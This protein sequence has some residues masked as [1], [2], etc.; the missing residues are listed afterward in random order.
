[1]KINYQMMLSCNINYPVHISHCELA[2]TFNVIYLN[3]FNTHTL[4][5]CELFFDI[6]YIIK[7]KYVLCIPFMNAVPENK[8]HIP[9]VSIFNKTFNLFLI[10]IPYFPSEIYETIFYTRI[11]TEIN[12]V[13]H[14]AVIYII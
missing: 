1:M 12:I 3:A 13:K 4:T 10:I 6:I 7:V 9:L 11:R 8:T 14:A 5:P 2:V